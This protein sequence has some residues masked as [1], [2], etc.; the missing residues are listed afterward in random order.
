VK[1]ADKGWTY[2]S[3]DTM[4]KRYA[5]IIRVNKQSLTVVILDDKAGSAYGRGDILNI[6]K[7]MWEDLQ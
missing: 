1:A 5:V 2:I 4:T 3:P 6:E 7:Y